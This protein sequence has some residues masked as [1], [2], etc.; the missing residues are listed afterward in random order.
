MGVDEPEDVLDVGDSADDN[1]IAE[2]RD[3]L[4]N[5]SRPGLRGEAANALGELGQGSKESVR[6]PI[7]SDLIAVVT[8]DQNDAVR[9]AAIDSLYYIDSTNVDT[10][11]DELTKQFSNGPTPKELR[12]HFE[13]WL[14]SSDSEFRIVGAAA[15]KRF[16]DDSILP[17][18]ESALKDP[19]ARVRAR[20]ARVYG[21]L[22]GVSADPIESLL[23]DERSLV[24]RAAVQTLGSIGGST[25]MKA[26]VSAMGA[27]D[28]HLRLV[29]ARQLGQF[30]QRHSVQTLVRALTDHSRSVRYRSAVSL[31]TIISTTDQLDVGNVPATVREEVDATELGTVADTVF[32]IATDA[33]DQGIQWEIQ[34]CAVW[35]LGELSSGGEGSE[36]AQSMV[37]LLQHDEETVVDLTAAYLKRLEGEQIERELQ[38]LISDSTVT[39][40]IRERARMIL[41]RVKRNAAAE[42]VEQS[43]E[44]TYVQKPKDYTLKH[45]G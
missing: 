4:Q 15:M 44:Y 16:G 34:L 37:P 8:N 1:D 41:Q 33:N 6:G 42:I 18:L 9:A 13:L 20:A 27:S 45:R 3:L 35:L 17:E 43:I 26:L 14:T 11:V 31:L 22:D 39:P 36:L 2:L 38:R 7:V 10:L 25:A 21:Q 40:E 5:G 19:D 29:A 12:D 28:S 24:R 32:E 23:S 30:D